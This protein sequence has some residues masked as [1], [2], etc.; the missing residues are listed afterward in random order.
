MNNPN[1]KPDVHADV[2]FQKKLEQEHQT[3]LRQQLKEA[4]KPSSYTSWCTIH[5]HT[6]P[7]LRMFTARVTGTGHVSSH[8]PCE[9][10]CNAVTLKHCSVLVDADGI[11]AC[12]NSDIG[13]RYACDAVIK[14]VTAYGKMCSTE[15]EFIQGIMSDGFRSSVVKRFA[16]RV[17][18]R[19]RDCNVPREQELR[20][21]MT[22]GTTL[23]YAVITDHWIASGNLGDGQILVFNEDF[24]IKVRSHTPKQS[25]AVAALV[26]PGCVKEDFQTALY[27][28]A[29]FDGVLMSS[30]G[31][32]DW[33]ERGNHF[34]RYALQARRRFL[35]HN[36]PYQAF[37]Y[38]EP[39]QVN[40][41]FSKCRSSD[42]CSVVLGT[43][44]ASG[45]RPYSK[46]L[47]SVEK[48]SDATLVKR[49]A[50]SCM[51]FFTRK[52]GVCS[53]INASDR[54][55]ASLPDLTCAV[56]EEPEEEW[57][58]N[59]V[60]FSRYKDH[61]RPTLELMQSMGMLKDSHTSPQSV[62]NLYQ[63]VM[64]LRIQ[65]HE[66]GSML[67]ESAPFNIT[68]EDGKL[69]VRKEALQ[70]Y[71]PDVMQKAEAGTMKLF[72]HIVGILSGKDAS[73]PVFDIGYASGGAMISCPDN[74]SE[75]LLQM[76]CH[77]R[78]YGLCNISAHDWKLSDGRTVPSKG[79]LPL[80]H[81]TVEFTVLDEKGNEQEH[82]CFAGKVNV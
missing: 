14:A 2:D 8:T 79:I 53:W 56:L 65:L 41:D 74:P 18:H 45:D 73:V 66:Q 76:V 40:K 68:V 47:R 42:D 27:P 80:E 37:C 71:G 50:P 51:S 67:N 43:W 26:N 22:Y 15:K 61:D 24:G 19:I 60:H 20:E 58:E 75:P 48:H 63:Q 12:V 49:W 38:E 57:E 46:V 23:M 33:L 29:L 69:F 17:M 30:D 28:R 78:Q 39:G 52:N 21:F 4:E 10:Y 36:A 77:K 6:E 7:E 31:M 44:K 35:Q 70:A 32:Y 54:R 72:H 3:M 34:F 59:G 25:S 55:L 1:P 9:D 16:R 62:L 5:S 82:Y 64:K 13:S 11:S 81:E